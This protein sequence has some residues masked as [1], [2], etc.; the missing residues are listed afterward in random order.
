MQWWP[1]WWCVDLSPDAVLGEV[2]PISVSFDRNAVGDSLPTAPAVVPQTSVLPLF[3]LYATPAPAP[4]I[5]LARRSW[6]LQPQRK[7]KTWWCRCPAVVDAKAAADVPVAAPTRLPVHSRFPRRLWGPVDVCTPCSVVAHP[8]RY[9]KRWIPTC[10]ISSARLNEGWH[11]LVSR[12]GGRAR[13]ASQCNDQSL[14]WLPPVGCRR[15]MP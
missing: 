7:R 6:W 5:Q 3:G 12:F 2:A 8:V 1:P 4:P 13:L 10:S 9:L 15:S 14:F 11:H